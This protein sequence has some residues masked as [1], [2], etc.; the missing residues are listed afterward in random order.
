MPRTSTWRIKASTFG[1]RLKGSGGDLKVRGKFTGIYV[2][3]EGCT[4][5]YE[6]PCQNFTAPAWIGFDHSKLLYW[7]SDL[8]Y[9]EY[10]AQCMYCPLLRYSIYNQDRTSSQSKLGIFVQRSMTLIF[11]RDCSSI[12]SRR[13]A[14]KSFLVR[15]IRRSSL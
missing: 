9:K 1:Q 6:M 4:D 11:S 14:L 15:M 2:E 8:R 13:V 3:K 5:V 7:F 10:F 12:I